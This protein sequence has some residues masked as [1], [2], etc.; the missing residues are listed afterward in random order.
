ME[1]GMADSITC[2]TFKPEYADAM[3]KMTQSSEPHA[4]ERPASSG[5]ETP[6]GTMG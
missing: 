4:M 3:L 6:G 1:M 5:M 2:P